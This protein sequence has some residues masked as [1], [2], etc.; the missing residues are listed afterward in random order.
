MLE[1]RT[2]AQSVLFE[3]NT[4][5]IM[6]GEDSH[7]NTSDTTEYFDANGTNFIYDYKMPE[8]LSHHCAKMFNTSHLFTTG[9]S[10]HSSTPT[11]SFASSSRG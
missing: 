5:F 9:G 7:G 1:E 3:N 10:K 11:N 8:H 6:G 2:F 4:W